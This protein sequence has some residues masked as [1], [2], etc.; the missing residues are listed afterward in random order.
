MHQAT[1]DI[2]TGKAM[3]P[4]ATDDLRVYEVDVDGDDIRILAD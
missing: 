4:P 3:S 2:R 1:F